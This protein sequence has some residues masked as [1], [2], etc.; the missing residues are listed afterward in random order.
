[1]LR[2]REMRKSDIPF[3]V[4]VSNEEFWGIPSRDFRRILKLDSHGSFIAWEGNRRVGIATTTSY[5]RQIAWIGNV[6]VKKQYRHRHIG[7]RL[8]KR[9]IDHLS[10][11]HVRH[12]ALYSFIENFQFYRRLGF[13]HGPRFLRL[14]REARHRSSAV[15]RE[16][17]L[18]PRGISRLLRADRKAFGA[19]RGQLL[20]LMLESGYAWYYDHS[21]GP[22]YSYILVKRYEDLYELG[23]W[24]S[25]RLDAT[26]LDSFFQSVLQRAS[27]KPIEVTCPLTHDD[28]SRILRKRKFRLINKGRVMFYRKVARIGEPNA[29]LAFGFLD[30]G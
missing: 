3:A 1:M 26:Q 13:V 17:T 23:P 14:R 4:R 15:A 24:V 21:A 10:E 25:F 19:D 8:V 5:G 18:E 16:A 11:L 7:Q 6:V 29:V 22:A 2:I 9:A 12:I 27:D 20:K 30:K 28:A